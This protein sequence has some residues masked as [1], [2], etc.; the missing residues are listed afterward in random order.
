MVLINPERFRSYGD[1]IKRV[2]G[3]YINAAVQEVRSELNR[4]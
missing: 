2:V 4:R 1:H 3:T